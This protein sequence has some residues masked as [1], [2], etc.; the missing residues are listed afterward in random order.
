MVGWEPMPP[1]APPE[2]IEP[3]STMM[4]LE[5][6]LRI[7]SSTRAW[8]P[9]PTAI[10]TITAATPMMMPSMVNA[11]RILLTRRA[12]RAMRRVAAKFIAALRPHPPG[13]WRGPAPRGRRES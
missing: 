7:C 11:E 2:V 13:Y 6:R 5:P 10:M 8:A 9:P 12:S 1:R 4:M 3:E